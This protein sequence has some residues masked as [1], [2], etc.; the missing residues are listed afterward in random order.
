MEYA[1]LLKV[2]LKLW[3]C[4]NLILFRKIS[5]ISKITGNNT[6]WFSNHGYKLNKIYW[7]HWVWNKK[8]L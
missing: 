4:H 2:F 3:K 5:W 6:K 8:T 7:V 1:N